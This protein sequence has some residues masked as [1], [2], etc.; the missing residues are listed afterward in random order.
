MPFD[1]FEFF[2]PSYASIQK[3]M[4]YLL[5]SNSSGNKTIDNSY[6]QEFT[7]IPGILSFVNGFANGTTIADTP[8]YTI[9]YDSIED[10]SYRINITWTEF[11]SN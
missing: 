6:T 7:T 1:S 3:E 10:I 4:L 9:C 11:I 2:E 5:S 8:N